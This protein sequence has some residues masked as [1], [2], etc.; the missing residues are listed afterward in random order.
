MDLT[1]TRYEIDNGVAVVT[2]NRPD[3]M[4]AFT[5]IMRKELI[6]IFTEADQDDAVR[7][8][9]VTGAGKAFCAGADLSVG[10]SAFD[11]SEKEGRKITISEHRDGGGQTTLAIFKCRKP[12]IAAINGHAVGVGITMTLAMDIRVVAGD[13]KIGFVFAR[14][15]VVLEAC[16]SWFL[17]RIVGISKAA[18]FVYTGRLFRAEEEATSG[19]FNYVVPSNQVLPKAMTIAREI[20]ENT[21]AVSVALSKGLLWHGLSEN[22]PQSAH[23]IDSR[24]F[25]WAGRQ[26]DAYE[27]IQS[28]LEK[29][30]PRF[31]MRPSTDMPDFYPWWKEPKV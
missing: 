30:A 5:S 3:K 11:R 10:G 21:S 24:C 18:E 19:L 26:K 8:V 4:N 25:F 7:V 27:G 12:V 29:R 20:A 16:S 23:L 1:Q 15:G 31:T 28:F 6:G 22:D 17:P 2:L 13:A 14:R 9:V